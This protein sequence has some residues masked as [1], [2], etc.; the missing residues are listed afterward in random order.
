[1]LRIIRFLFVFLIILSGLAIHLRNDQAVLFDYYLGSIEL[2]FSLFLIGALIIG[3]V[4]GIVACLPAL[5]RLS[6]ENRALTARIR[7]S[8][9]ELDN[10]RTIPTRN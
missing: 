3:T 4:L 1:M 6:Q 2:P 8:E 10:L 9:K 5:M 7:I